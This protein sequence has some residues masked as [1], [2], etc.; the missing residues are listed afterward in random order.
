ML[1]VSWLSWKFCAAVPDAVVEVVADVEAVVDAADVAVD[2]VALLLG[3]SYHPGGLALTRRLAAALDL[4]PGQRVIDV[5]SGPGA[6]ARLTC[7]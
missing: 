3:V 2:A 1:L 6:T 5:A 7:T 4:R